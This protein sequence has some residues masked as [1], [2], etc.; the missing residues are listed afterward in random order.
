MFRYS[1]L[2][3]LYCAPMLGTITDPDIRMNDRL[4]QH[5]RR[6][7]AFNISN[8]SFVFTLRI[9]SIFVSKQPVVISDSAA[10]GI[11]L[12]HVRYEALRSREKKSWRFRH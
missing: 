3:V 8:Q 9:R 7:C 11:Y 12:R 5:V 10:R 6:G 2:V 4:T 1:G